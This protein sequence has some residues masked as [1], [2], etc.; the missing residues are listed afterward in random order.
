LD[1]E[2]SII[3]GQGIEVEIDKSK[4]DKRRYNKGH[5]VQGVRVFGGIERTEEKKFFICVVSDRSAQTL[6][7]VIE[8]HE[9]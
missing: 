9:C 6:I 1:V 4:F 3:E 2:D 7:E 5:H 8:Q